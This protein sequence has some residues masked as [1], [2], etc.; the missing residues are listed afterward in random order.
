[1]STDP[2]KLTKDPM[3]LARIIDEHCEREQNRLSYRRATWL[4]ALYYMMGARQFDVFDPVSGTVRYSYLDDEE[5]ME[6]QSSELLSAVDKI[7]GR[8]SSLDYRPLV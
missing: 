2:I 4:V 8:L 5:K 6:F 3:M 7:S 1:M